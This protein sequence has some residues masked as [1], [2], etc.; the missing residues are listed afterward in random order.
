M[1]QAETQLKQL[2]ERSR[3]QLTRPFSNVQRRLLYVINITYLIL[4]PLFLASEKLA[5]GT[6]VPDNR[7]W[8]IYGLVWLANLISGIYAFFTLAENQLTFFGRPLNLS[9]LKHSKRT[10]NALRWISVVSVMF[11]S[12]ANML[13]IGNPS[14]DSLLTDFALAHSLIVLAAMILG[15]P[16]MFTW[17]AVVIGLL[18]WVTFGKLEGYSYRYNYLT[19]DESV[20]Y[21]TALTQR[22]AW[23]LDRQA[24]LKANHLNPPQASRYF[25][26]W[27]IFIVVATATAYYFAGV[28]LDLFKIIPEVTEDIKDAIEATKVAEER[29]LLQQ[30]ETLT[31]ELKA[32]KAQVNPHFL[33]NTLNYFYIRSQEVDPELADSIIKLSGIM[34]Y[35]M[36]ED[37]NTARLSEEINY[38]QQFISLHQVRYPLQIRFNVTGDV[39]SKNILPFLLIGL[40]ENAFKHGN[41]TDPNYPFVV[42][43]K[44]TDD[45]IEFF[46]SNLKNKKQ[47]FES[48]HI[49]LTNTRQR[50]ER[51]YEQYSFDINE[52]DD[53]FSCNL[54]LLNQRL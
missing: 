3:Q 40:V 50:L 52:T 28:A 47:R 48:N 8:F 23:A 13:G 2:L 6:Y 34:R 38:M 1:N 11:M 37:F 42:D 54:L 16:A 51:A 24:I 36:R 14:N 49:G 10:E 20:R 32:L 21:Q 4:T 46:T 33:Y 45:R 7:L 5:T 29:R 27:L 26:T 18:V 41:M 25:N 19:P 9:T 12:V 15:R 30:Q 39:E 43:I 44:A 17:A 31:T 22:K 35:S 53:T